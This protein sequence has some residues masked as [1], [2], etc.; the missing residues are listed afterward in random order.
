MKIWFKLMKQSEVPLFRNMFSKRTI[1]PDFT[2]THLWNCINKISLSWQPFWK[3]HFITLYRVLSQWN[4]PDYNAFGWRKCSI[5]ETKI[6]SPITVFNFIHLL[7]ISMWKEAVINS[8][9]F[10]NLLFFNNI[11]VSNICWQIQFDIK[12]KQ[13]AC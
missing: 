11:T 9:G 5:K 8:N 12:I 7:R 13:R 10:T 1:L 6:A 4:A 2:L 3:R